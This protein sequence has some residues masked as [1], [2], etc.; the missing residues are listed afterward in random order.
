MSASPGNYQAIQLTTTATDLL[1]TPKQVGYTIGTHTHSDQNLSISLQ[2]CIHQIFRMYENDKH[3]LDTL[4]PRTHT[5]T[6]T[7]GWTVF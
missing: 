6:Q 5:H 4:L 7:D 1:H 2:G 3:S